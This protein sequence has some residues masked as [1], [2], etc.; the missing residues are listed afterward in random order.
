MKEN[1]F[2]SCKNERN[3]LADVQSIDKVNLLK[4]TEAMF[5]K[6]SKQICLRPKESDLSFA[7]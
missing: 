3:L 4:K 6:M 5:V 7:L 1:V 2:A